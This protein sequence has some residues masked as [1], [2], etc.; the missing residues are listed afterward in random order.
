[1]CPGTPPPKGQF[2]KTVW[3]DRKFSDSIKVLDAIQDPRGEKMVVL[4]LPSGETELPARMVFP[5]GSEKPVI[6]VQVAS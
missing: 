5:V 1:M 3:N 6:G 4:S 2:R